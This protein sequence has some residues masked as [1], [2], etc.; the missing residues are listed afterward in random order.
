MVHYL[1]E[2][3]TE[4]NIQTYAFMFYSINIDYLMFIK[5]MK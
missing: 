3:I 5:K 4:Y 2:V 1:S